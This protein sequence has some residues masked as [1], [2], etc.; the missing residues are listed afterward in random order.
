MNTALCSWD[1]EKSSYIH[2]FSEQLHEKLPLSRMGETV[3]GPN[4]GSTL[5]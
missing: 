2:Y 3:S 1:S 5:V 4:N